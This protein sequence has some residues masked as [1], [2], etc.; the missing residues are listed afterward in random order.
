M[1]LSESNE[2]NNPSTCTKRDRDTKPYIATYL[3]IFPT[4]LE[5]N[6]LLHGY[7]QGCLEPFVYVGN[8]S[9]GLM[10]QSKR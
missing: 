6:L 5:C 10:L 1:E 9:T 7:I 8:I 4:E 2:L 3:F